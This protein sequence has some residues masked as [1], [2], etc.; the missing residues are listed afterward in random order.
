MVASLPVLRRI[1]AAVAASLGPCGRTVVRRIPYSA[2]VSW[3]PRGRVGIREHLVSQGL[4]RRRDAPGIDG[5][6][7]L[8]HT[9]A[10][11]IALRLRRP[12]QPRRPPRAR[13]GDRHSPLYVRPYGGPCSA[14]PAPPSAG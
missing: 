6:V 3:C 5:A 8:L 12:V 1:A 9:Q 11:G 7:G 2:P 14:S 10:G 4:A 13:R